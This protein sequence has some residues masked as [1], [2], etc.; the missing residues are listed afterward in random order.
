MQDYEDQAITAKVNEL[1]ETCKANSAIVDAH[2]KGYGK[3]V[4]TI[5]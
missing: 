2:R 5:E 1:V 3:Y 4:I